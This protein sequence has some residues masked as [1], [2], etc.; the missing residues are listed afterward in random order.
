M[1]N[2]RRL[3]FIPT[4][5][6]GGATV[7]FRKGRVLSNQ[8]LGIFHGDCVKMTSSGDWVACASGTDEQLLLG[9]VMQGATFID[10]NNKRIE[11]KFLPA[12][13][14]YSG[15]DFEPELGSYIYVVDNATMVE[16]EANVA[17]SAIALTDLNINYPIVLTAGSTVTGL[18]KHELNATGRA[19]TST[20]PFRV[21]EP[22]RRADND[23]SLIDCKVIC[24]IN[25]GQAEPVTSIYTGT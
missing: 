6:S 11:S 16:F 7:T 12:A 25:A 3:G 20:F 13:T 22:V 14:V 10:A 9:S 19:T 18:S 24:M 5:Q 1:A 17:N 2:V 23:L 15:T 8:T 4:R 21:R